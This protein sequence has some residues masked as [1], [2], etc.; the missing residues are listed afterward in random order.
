MG[1]G[2]REPY[3]LSQADDNAFVA[4]LNRWRPDL[5]DEWNHRWGTAYLVRQS[6]FRNDL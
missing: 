6:Y 3:D 4:V 5:A 1:T 2:S